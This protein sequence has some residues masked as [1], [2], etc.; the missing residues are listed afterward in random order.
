MKPQ[1]FVISRFFLRAGWGT[2]VFLLLGLVGARAATLPGPLV[3]S[4]WLADNLGQVV[5]L[6]V[7][8]DTG[9]FE[10]RPKGAGPVNPC[11]PGK[12]GGKPLVVAGHI[13]G[14]VL[15]PWK[16]VT[17]KRKVNGVVIK[18]MAPSAKDFESLMQKS[19]VN[20]DSA[21]VITGK[22]QS[23]VQTALAARL[24]W[25]L[26]YF[27]HDNVALL[28]GGTAQWIRDKRKVKFGRSKAGKGTFKAT[29]ERKEIRASLEDVMTLSK[30]ENGGEQLVDVRGKDVYLG[31]AYSKKFVPPKGKGHIPGAKSFPVYFMADTMG[32][33]ANIHSKDEIQN[34]AGIVGMDL[35]KPTTISCNSGV[36]ASIGWFVLHE[37]LGN[38]NVRVYDGSM[39][40]WINTGNPV[41]SMKIE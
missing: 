19:G 25:T 13:P 17:S 7:R 16:N 36:M 11:G 24:Y 23:P 1:H 34:V 2:L 14:A 41:V 20:N 26:K 35:S 5:V 10:K 6:D 40:E 38:K 8:K 31:L 37:M 30:G 3:D 15:V 21:I 39:H 33:A 9:S 32:P 27:G 4:A 12:K 29:T 28:N 18:A 22:G